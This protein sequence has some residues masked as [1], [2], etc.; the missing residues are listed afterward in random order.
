MNCEQMLE[1]LSARLDGELNQTEEQAVQAH[2]EQCP[3]CRALW[4]QISALQFS[5]DDLETIPAP[6]DFAQGVMARVR[7]E[8]RRPKVVPLWKHRQVKALM[9]VAACAALIVGLGS[10]RMGNSKEAAAPMMAAPEAAMIESDTAVAESSAG[11]APMAYDRAPAALYQKSAECVPETTAEAA[12]AEG[13]VHSENEAVSEEMPA[14]PA[15]P[16]AAETEDRKDKLQPV[17]MLSEL[18]EGAEEILGDAR[19]RDDGARLSCLITG[20]QARRLC[21]LVEEQGLSV[22]TGEAA[23]DTSAEC[24]DLWLLI[25]DTAE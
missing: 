19:W 21:I 3:E 8:S 23:A 16:E 9:G 22:L 6:E 25:L 11:E 20:E 5:L 13:G 7:Q 15:A 24:A 2:L 12:P 14:E 4:E 17:L 10:I 1:L 18:P